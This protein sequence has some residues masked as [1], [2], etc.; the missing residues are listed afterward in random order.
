M[1][2]K[3]NCPVCGDRKTKGVSERTGPGGKFTK[4]ETVF[5]CPNCNNFYF[6]TSGLVV[7]VKGNVK[8]PPDGFKLVKNEGGGIFG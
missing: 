1:V 2:E 4:I 7:D 3:P 8:T 5:K 6:P